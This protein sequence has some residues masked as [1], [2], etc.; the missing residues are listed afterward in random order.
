M[1]AAS[2][3]NSR[4]FAGSATMGLAPSRL[5]E[6]FLM[7]EF[8][9]QLALAFTS[10]GSARMLV[11]IGVFAA[12]LLLMLVLRPTRR[13]HPA[14]SAAIWTITIVTLS[15]F[16]PTTNGWVGGAAQAALYVAIVAPL[17]WV[18]RLRVDI[19][20]IRRALLIVW[21]F[22]TISAGAGIVQ[23]Y[24][25]GNLQPNLSAA[26]ASV[27]DDY[28]KGLHL[29]TPDGR[30]IIR[31]MGLSDVP[32]GAATAGLYAALF[33]MGF[34][35]VRPAFWIRMVCVASMSIG[36]VSILLS[37]VRSAL[38]VLI[39]SVVGFAAVMI[40]RGENRQSVVFGAL[41]AALLLSGIHFASAAG[42][43]GVA[44]RLTSFSEHPESVYLQ[45]RGR[46][47]VETVDEVPKYP[48]GAGLG[49]WGMINHYFGD[50][51]NS[52]DPP[53]WVE[54]Q[55]TGW[56]L[57]GGVPLVIAYVIAIAIAVRATL[58]IA[59]SRDRNMLWPWA[60]M[61]FGYDVGVIANTFAYP[62]FIGQ[63][64]LEFW[65][66]NALL[67]AAATDTDAR[68]FRNQRRGM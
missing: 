30:W 12:S 10:L 32:G 17:F 14:S 18:P 36:I 16:H 65:L 55:W 46:F 47:L 13:V 64:G 19:A 26:V 62:V 15:M 51:S 41:L 24:F 58:K 38:V 7:F 50:S 49:R 39:V 54:I 56:L 6:T 20:T 9:A 61:L 52:D 2:V 4:R 53:L 66:F 45:E 67:Y 40:W 29:E 5:V 31:P 28:V 27:G 37:Q 8:A 1:M 23:F 59:L 22:Q 68:A 33:A 3:G 34:F 57:D 25:P 48:L 60:A 21:I 63:S 42:G 11:R 44:S 35:L 43:L